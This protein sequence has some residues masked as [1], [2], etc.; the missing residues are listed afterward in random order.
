MKSIGSKNLIQLFRKIFF[1]VPL[2]FLIISLVSSTTLLAQKNSIPNIIL[3]MADDLGYGDVGYN[4]PIIKTPSIDK[5]AKE[6]VQFNR[7][8]VSVPV[9]SP[10]RGSILTG[11]NPYRYGIYSAN[12]GH[13]KKEE[14]CLA[15]VLRAA[16]YTTGH[17]GKWH[18]GTLTTAETDGNRGRLHDSSHYSPPWMN[19]FDVSFS[20]EARV[21][22]WDPLVTPANYDVEIG[23]KKAGEPIGSSYWIGEGQKETSNLQGDDSRIIM[24]RVIPFIKKSESEKKN[25]FAVIWFHT[26]H[27][28]VITGEQYRNFYKEYSEEEQHYYGAITAMDEQI[29]R[30]RSFLRDLKV[31]R[32]T[33][34]IFQS[35]NGP[36]GNSKMGK[37]QGSALDF[38]GRK[39]SLYEGGIRVP[40]I[41][42]WPDSIKAH[43][44]IDVPV[45]TT[46]I[47]P[48]LLS[49]LN[50]NPLNLVKP[51]DG[52]NIFP[53][54]RGKVT[55]S[56]PICFQFNNQ[57]AV[58]DDQFKLYSPNRGTTYELYDLLADKNEKNDLS[59]EKTDV[60]NNLKKILTDW[61]ESCKQS[62]AGK[63]YH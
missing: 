30:L 33:I 42:V 3:I 59:K 22:T 46:D 54:I 34:I 6:G 49:I 36:E 55:R 50:L 35:D 18:L 58:I 10:T 21:A 20:T 5:M 27:L 43:R 51:L 8:Y 32:N 61:L 2:Q 48:T 38:R 7:F 17:F 11:R 19:G 39:R 37:N 9:C 63:D 56:S 41:L 26:P 57:I 4:N 28:P 24:D 1:S 15:E 45:T 14:L 47:F 52:I 12:V 25:F 16:N 13:L 60:V 40:A 53:F 62:D 23:N 29:G 44:K 31:D